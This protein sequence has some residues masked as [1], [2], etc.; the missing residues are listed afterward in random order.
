MRRHV[1]DLLAAWEA[2]TVQLKRENELRAE[3]RAGQVPRPAGGLEHR[4]VRSAFEALFGDLPARE[5][6]G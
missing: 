3:H 6:P 5:V 1:A 4:A 2:V